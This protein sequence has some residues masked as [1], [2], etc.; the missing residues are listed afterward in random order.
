MNFNTSLIVSQITAY[1]HVPCVLELYV[2]RLPLRSSPAA[3]TK[4]AA[5]DRARR[6]PPS[7]P[8]PSPAEEGDAPAAQFVDPALPQTQCPGD[9]KCVSEMFCDATGTMTAFRVDLTEE[10]KEERG[11]LIVRTAL[12][13]IVWVFVG[14][15]FGLGFGFYFSYRAWHLFG[16]FS[17][18]QSLALAWIFSC[19]AW[20]LF[21]FIFLLQSLALLWFFSSCRAWHL[22]F[23]LFYAAILS[24]KQLG[25]KLLERDKKWPA[26]KHCFDLTTLSQRRK[27]LRLLDKYIQQSVDK[28]I[29]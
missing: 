14:L 6:P 9:M 20:H 4:S 16:I 7:F 28:Y 17:L 2:P 24:R 11:E 27:T 13:H 23:C 29:L 25:Q 1:V 19:R 5:R 3:S 26:L 8:P 18:L 12:T 15:V 10:E 22:L 21:S